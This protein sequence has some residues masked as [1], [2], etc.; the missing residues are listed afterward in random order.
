MTSA[1]R[2]AQRRDSARA[3]GKC[4][5]CLTRKAARRGAAFNCAPCALAHRGRAKKSYS[6][7]TGYRPR[8]LFE[9]RR[10]SASTGPTAAI[11]YLKPRDHREQPL[12]VRMYADAREL[13]CFRRAA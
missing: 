2:Q 11:L 10:S 13:P 6:A 8:W 1:E 3:R 7:A 4:G 9:R 5:T 12:V